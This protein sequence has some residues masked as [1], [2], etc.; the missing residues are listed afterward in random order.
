MPLTLEQ[1]QWEQPMTPDVS[2]PAWE[3]EVAGLFGGFVPGSLK[4]VASS[5][6]VRRAY[7]DCVR[8]QLAVLGRPE[9][10]LAG[11]VTSQENACRYCYGSAR[12]RMKMIGFTDEMIDR[13][14]RNVQ[15][16]DAEPRE[17]ELVSFCR[18]LARSKPRPSRRAR[19][20]LMQVGFSALETAELAFVVAEVG[21]CNRVSTLLAVPPDIEMEAHA[22]K[23]PGL[24]SKLSAWLPGKR[25]EMNI[26]PPNHPPPRFDGPY[27]SLVRAL[28]GSPAAAFL[29]VMLKEAFSSL[30]LP[31]RT[32]SLIFA[33]IAHT[34]QC[35]LCEGEAG[36]LLEGEGLSRADLD[37]V[38]AN[39][40]SPKLTEM[41]ALLIPWARDTVWMPEQPARI[42]SRTRPLVGALGPEVVIEAVG[43]AALANSCV[44]LTMLQV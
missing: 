6:W 15:L 18:N 13:I 35:D 33:V 42:Q 39:L 25:P 28:E 44:R 26:P 3:A 16:A 7:L 10:E 14:E 12:G 32:L 27:A 34:L 9:V 40:A 37:E 20:Q 22:R 21:F 36:K 23:A 5:H 4:R 31:R 1:L 2:D 19:E 30:T 24:W 11:L 29:E 41:E 8:C 17:R 38:L 43:A